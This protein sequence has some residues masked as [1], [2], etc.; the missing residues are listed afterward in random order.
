MLVIAD[1]MHHCLANSK[2]HSLAQSRSICQ[3]YALWPGSVPQVEVQCFTVVADCPECLTEDNLFN[4][5][6]LSRE[7]CSLPVVE[8]T[9]PMAVTPQLGKAGMTLQ[10]WYQVQVSRENC[11]RVSLHS[12]KV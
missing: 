7:S 10:C 3:C 4:T 11:L 2:M 12:A 1:G 9:D 5:K 6:T 8:S